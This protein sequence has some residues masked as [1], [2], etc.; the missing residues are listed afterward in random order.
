MK[1]SL[2]LDGYP[3]VLTVEECAAVLRVGVKSIYRA[4]AEDRIPYRKI[5]TRIVFP[6][7]LLREFL[8]EKPDPYA[9][10]ALAGDRAAVEA[11]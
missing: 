11:P 1:L 3:D 7:C 4:V 2:N 9:L 5:G 8:G 6:K 10:P